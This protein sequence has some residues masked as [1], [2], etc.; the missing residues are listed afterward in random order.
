MCF[1]QLAFSLLAA[2]LVF[3]IWK[4]KQK[5]STLKEREVSMNKFA[6]FIQWDDLLSH[7]CMPPLPYQYCFCDQIEVEQLLS[8]LLLR[9]LN[10]LW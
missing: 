1:C 5:E 8:P 9:F 4:E 10:V 3:D 2:S 6:N 7:G